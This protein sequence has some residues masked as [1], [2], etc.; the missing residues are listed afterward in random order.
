MYIPKLG[1]QV[2]QHRN[3]FAKLLGKSILRFSGWRFDG[4]FPNLSKMI[5][6][7]APHTSNW[8]AYYGFAAV[9]AM[10]L[11]V[12]WMAKRS[13]FPKPLR[14]LLRALG[15]IP[16]DRSASQGVVYQT[17]AA[18][19]DRSELVLVVT[20]EGTRKRVPRWKSG[21]YYMARQAGVPISLG[22]L[23]YGKKCLGFGPLI[24]PGDD[25]ENDFKTIQAFYAKVTARHPE[26]FNP[27]IIGKPENSS[28]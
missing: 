22:F 13:L 11:R 4:Q 9:L 25:M 5:L 20:P 8:D 16:I 10:G 27:N 23:D 7:G 21:F 12:N 1:D 19:R 18:F 2:P 15:G 3:F 24:T 14:G 17:Q 26:Y 6:I 28:D